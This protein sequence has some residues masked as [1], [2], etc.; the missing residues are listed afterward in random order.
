MNK[1]IKNIF[2]GAIFIVTLFVLG[3][4]TGILM[5]ACCTKGC[6]VQYPDDNIVV[7]DTILLS[8]DDI[9]VFD[10]N[11][12]YIFV[13]F[14]SNQDP[15]AYIPVDANIYAEYFDQSGFPYLVCLEDSMW[16]YVCHLDKVDMCK[17]LMK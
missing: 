16:I 7:P 6:A 14:D 17:E 4:G 11:G 8:W 10:D 15:Y 13:L 5:N 2:L 9:E 12:E 3:T 1:L